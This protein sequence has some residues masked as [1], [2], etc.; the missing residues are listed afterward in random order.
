MRS[1]SRAEIVLENLPPSDPTLE[2]VDSKEEASDAEGIEG[3]WEL[4]PKSGITRQIFSICTSTLGPSNAA[5]PLATSPPEVSA[6]TPLEAQLSTPQQTVGSPLGFEIVPFPGDQPLSNLRAGQGS[7]H[8]PNRHSRHNN[9]PSRS[10]GR[11]HNHPLMALIPLAF[12]RHL[13]FH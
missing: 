10:M 9:I 6:P 8:Y 11:E 2:L 12:R 7:L 4:E 1:V 3:T 5:L 13:G